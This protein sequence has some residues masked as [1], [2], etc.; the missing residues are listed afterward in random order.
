MNIFYQRI[1]GDIHK[2][3]KLFHKVKGKEV[4]MQYWRAHILVFALMEFLLLGYSEK[5]LEI[6]RLSANNRILCKL[7][8]KYKRFITEYKDKEIINTCHESSGN[9]WVCWFQGMKKA[10]DIVQ[11]C[12]QSLLQNIKDREIILITEDNYK[13]YVKFPDV[14]QKKIEQ[15]IISKTH[16]SDLLRLELLV[17][18]GGTWIDSTVYCTGEVPEYMLN[19]ELFVFQKLKPG[20]DG[21]CTSISN[22][23]ITAEKENPI[24]KLTLA[25]LYQYWYTYDKLID[26]FIFHDFFQLSTECYPEVWKKVIPVSNSTPHILLLRLFEKFDRKVWNSIKQQTCIHKL[27]YKFDEKNNFIPDTYYHEI[28]NKGCEK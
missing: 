27:T 28:F 1:T 7:R 22:W 5:S 10:P 15:G 13:N 23:F 8:K 17:N 11:Q 4:L 9:I 12:Y 19:S 18:Y 24:L 21:H 6:L 14:I 20:L 26:Y 25:L 16:M 2:F 3:I